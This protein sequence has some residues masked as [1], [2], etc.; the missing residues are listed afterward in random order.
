MR[1]LTKVNNICCHTPVPQLKTEDHTA[2]PIKRS[3]NKMTT[4]FYAT[5]VFSAFVF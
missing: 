4:T 5:A 1:S 2:I 3:T